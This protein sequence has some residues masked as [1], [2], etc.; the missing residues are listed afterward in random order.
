M[1]Y[2]VR[3]KLIEKDILKVMIDFCISGCYTTLSKV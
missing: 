3:G 1:F 2:S